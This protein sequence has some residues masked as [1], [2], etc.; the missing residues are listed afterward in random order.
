MATL[1]T[2]RPDIH[3]DTTSKALLS[4]DV[5]ALR[6]HRTVR[7]TYR[8]TEARYDAI[9]TQLASLESRM[10]HVDETLA[11]LVDQVANMVSE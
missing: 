4:V 8:R 6:H 1:Q 5:T 9:A 11:D 2:S 7:E 10:E 3:R